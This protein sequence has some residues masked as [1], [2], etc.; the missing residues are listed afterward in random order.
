MICFLVKKEENACASFFHLNI[1]SLPKHYDDLCILLESLSLRF[2]FVAITETWLSDHTNELHGVPNYTMES[3]YWKCKKGDGEA[4]Y[5]N[6]NIPYIVREDLEF[7]D[8]EMESLFIE[9]DSKVFQT[10]CNII[11]GVVYRM[12]DSSIDIFNDRVADILNLINKENKLFYMLGDL[13]IDLLKCDEHR[14]TSSL[15]DILY[16]NNVY[17]LITKPT[18]ITQN[19]ATLI[20]HISTNNFDVMGNH[21]QGILCT[22][23]SDHYAVA[24]VAGNTKNQVKDTTVLGVKRDLCQ[25]NVHKFIHKMQQIDWEVVMNLK[26]A[27]GAY[28]ESHAVVTKLYHKSF[29]YK[30]TNKPYFDRKLWLTSALK[31]SIKIRNILYVNRNKGVNIDEQWSKYK[32]YRKNLY[33][34]IRATER[35]YYQDQLT[36]HKSNLKKSWQII[37]QLS[38]NVNTDFQ[39]QNLSLIVTLLQMENEFLRHSI[40]FFDNVGSNLANNIPRSHKDPTEYISHGINEWFYLMPVT[41]EGTTKIIASFKDSSAGWDELKTVIVKNIKHCIAKPLYH[42]CNL[43]FKTGVFPQHM[44]IANVVLIYKS[45]DEDMYSNYRPVSVLRVFS[46]LIERLMYNMLIMFVTNNDLLYKY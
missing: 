18:R 6:D 19:S 25:I 11:I 15:I 36:K 7:F 33:H 9:I 21:K 44:K 40:S 31:E 28:S 24:H 42:L 3:R 22:D 34:L 35:Q 38:I 17:P 20:D 5:V 39:P 13:N 41:E 43:S 14:L 1:K 8:Y 2:T 29:P 30:K 26:E 27:Q 37:K 23:I 12:P 45:G 10:P 32:I 46:K 4:L 16:S